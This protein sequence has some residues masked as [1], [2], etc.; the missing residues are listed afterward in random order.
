MSDVRDD[1]MF[2]SLWLISNLETRED[3][4]AV[5]DLL[6]HVKLPRRCVLPPGNS[7]ALEDTSPFSVSEPFCPESDPCGRGT[8]SD[9]YGIGSAV[10]QVGRRTGAV[11]RK[12]VVYSQQE[13]INGTAS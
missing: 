12:H 13:I 4:V 6:L 3:N 8:T 2:F 11:A 10:V 9:C 7:R 1:I 5:S